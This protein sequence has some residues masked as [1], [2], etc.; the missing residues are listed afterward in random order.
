MNPSTS[1]LRI[2]PREWRRRV[3]DTGG[4]D[5]DLLALPSRASCPPQTR[6][7]PRF[8]SRI[9]LRLSCERAGALGSRPRCS[10]AMIHSRHMALA[11]HRVHH[12]ILPFAMLGARHNAQAHLRASHIKAN[13][14]HSQSADRPSGAAFVRLPARRSAVPRSLRSARSAERRGAQARAR[15]APIL[16]R[17]PAGQS[18]SALYHLSASRNATR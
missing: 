10:R 13:A 3:A 9:V 4:I 11:R 12:L 7:A 16:P 5:R 18:G 15:P 8:H 14:K 6:D 17:K 2:V 1:L